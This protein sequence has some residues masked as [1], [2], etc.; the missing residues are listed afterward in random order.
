MTARLSSDLDLDS[1]RRVELLGVI[2]EELGT[3]VDD[4]GVVFELYNEPFPQNNQNT[5]AAWQCWRDGCTHPQIKWGQMV[6]FD[7]YEAAGMQ[8][9]VSA[10]REVGAKQLI[11]LGGVQYSNSVSR[12]LDYAPQDPLENLG[13]AW[14]V[15]N[16]NRCSNAT[17]WNSEPGVVS[18]QVPLLATEIGQDDCQ[19]T[20]VNPLMQF[21]DEHRSSYLAWWWNISAGDCVPATSDTHGAGAPLSLITDYD[22]PT[23]KSAFGQA[24]YDHLTQLP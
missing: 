23:P 15:Y 20:M 14:H 7:S 24:I 3:F 21:L 18:A 2:E 1:L 19:A 17:C 9:L 4:D 12:W 16:F 6:A 5:E 22:C 13:A 10:V 11:L 8:E